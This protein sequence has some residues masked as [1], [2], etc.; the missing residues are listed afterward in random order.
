M[1]AVPVPTLWD[2][3]HDRMHLRDA[4]AHIIYI[5]YDDIAQRL[6]ICDWNDNH[7]SSG[8]RRRIDKLWDGGLWQSE[9]LLGQPIQN[10]KPVLPFTDHDSA[11]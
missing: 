9:W 5:I 2:N 7:G 1:N 6:L 4:D 3:V 8:R 10:F 11:R